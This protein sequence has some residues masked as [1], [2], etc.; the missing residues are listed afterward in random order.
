MRILDI[1]YYLACL[2]VVISVVFIFKKRKREEPYKNYIKLL[3][4][5]I[6]F[7]FLIL[8]VENVINFS[9]SSSSSEAKTV[10]T[11]SPVKQDTIKK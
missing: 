10:K 7:A 6:G 9:G 8:I 5:S 4:A 2:G 1:L 11:V 3:A